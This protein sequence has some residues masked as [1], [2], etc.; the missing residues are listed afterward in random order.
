[1]SSYPTLNAADRILARYAWGILMS[2]SRQSTHPK[3]KSSFAQWGVM[4]R[5]TLKEKLP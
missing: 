2:L 1:M 4:L 5:E 3:L